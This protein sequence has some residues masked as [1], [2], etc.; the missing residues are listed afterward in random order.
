MDAKLSRYAAAPSLKG[1]YLNLYERLIGKPVIPVGVEVERG[2]DGS[3]TRD[4]V[5][6]ALKLAMVSAEG[7]SLREKASE[8]AALFGNLKL[9][10]DYYICK[11]VDFLK[12]KKRN[13]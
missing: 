1:D 12:K 8:A 13:V 7:K 4:G 3:F 5:D 6:K 10:R 2:E 11:F 9:H